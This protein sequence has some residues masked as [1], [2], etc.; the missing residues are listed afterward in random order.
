MKV[1]SVL[2]AYNEEKNIAGPLKV[3]IDSD[4]ID[5]I[6]V[7]DDGSVD[8]TFQVVENNFPQ[9]K[10]LRHQQ[11]MGKGDA[12]I[13]G[14]ESAK[15]PVLFFCDADLRG[16]T[17]EHIAELL[18][19]VIKRKFK[20]VVG[21]PEYMNTLRKR[22]KQDFSEFYLGLGGQKVLLKKDF[23]SI[24][25]LNGSNYGVEHKI[26]SYYEMQKWAFKYIVL[27]DLT[28]VH[29]VKKWGV[30]GLFKEAD[31]FKTFAKQFLGL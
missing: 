15:N 5:E 4:L 1:S 14:A 8:K 29:K 3:L 6:I 11:N 2:P 22:K 28:H 26:I 25:E 19:P 30:K 18:S 31:A 7:V 20:M 17:K 27:Q 10:V 9:V 12:L 13:T 23:L 24:P 16:L 21:M